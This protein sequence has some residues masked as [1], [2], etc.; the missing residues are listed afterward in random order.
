MKVSTKLWTGYGLLLVLLGSLLVYHVRIIGDLAEAQ[1][2][3]TEVSVRLSVSSAEQLYRLDR[4]VDAGQKFGVTRDSLYAQLY[5]RTAAEM[6]SA[7]AVLEGLSRGAPEGSRVRA[8]IDEWESFRGPD[9]PP[10]IPPADVLAAESDSLQQAIIDVSTAARSSMLAEK[11]RAGRDVERARRSA[12]IVGGAALVAGLSIILLIIRSISGSLNRLSAATREVAQGKFGHR[13]GGTHD[14]EFREL[15]ENFNQMV[16][17]LE[18]VDELKRGFIS[19]ISHDLKSP[20]ASMKEAM[21]VLIDGIPGPLNARQER[22]LRLGLA[23]GDRLS[24]MI[25]DLLT[26]SQLESHAIGYTFE[27]VDLSDVA[28]R[29]AERLEARLQQAD[30]K[31]QV[32]VPD[33]LVVACDEDRVSQVIENLL[34]NAL[35][36]SPRGSAIELRL[37]RIENGGEPEAEIRVSDRGPGVPEEDRAAI[38]ERFV[39][40][41]ELGGSAAGVGLGL[42]ICRE[43]VAAHG[44]RIGVEENP[45]GGSTF[46]FTLPLEQP[47]VAPA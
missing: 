15:A 28:R 9:D 33:R 30:V 39:Q 42:T 43:I 17:R 25:S 46:S 24:S 29:A 21:Q 10:R 22:L 47:E 1:E 36:H 20:L 40:R 14:E 12:W 34:D 31:P 8:L 35:K 44:G 18:E 45:G 6:D 13:L 4:L 26:L 41:G 7:L 38:F 37:H 11:E 19:G 3:V 2:R 16:H 23:S 32:D 5:H 27:P